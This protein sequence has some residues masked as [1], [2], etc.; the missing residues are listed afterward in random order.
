[1]K[2]IRYII[3]LFAILVLFSACET[4]FDTID[5][6]QDITVVYGLLDQKEQDQYIKINKAFL[7]EGNA[8][9]Y[10]QEADS[11]NYGYL[12]DVS[13]DE[14]SE[15]GDFVR[16]IVLDT[17]T[18]YGK[19]PGVFYADKQVVYHVKLENWDEIK[20]I[21]NYPDTVRIDTMWLNDKSTFKLS[22]KNPRSGKEITSET[23]LVH[24][25]RYSNQAQTINFSTDPDKTTTF[26]WYKAENGGLNEF[27]LMFN[28]KE[29][30][31]NSSDTIEKSIELASSLVSP[32]SYGDENSYIYK[33]ANFYSS[34]LSSIPYND[35]AEE[36]NVV[37]RYTGTVVSRVSVA[38]EELTLYMQVYEPSTSIVQEKPEYTNIENGIGIFSARYWRPQSKNLH[39]DVLANLKS[40]DNNILKFD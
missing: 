35:P 23:K 27:Q 2:K 12:L 31:A 18:V 28:Y 7:G 19:E 30:Y 34:S 22:I 26:S 38:E 6:Y 10:A 32:T 40:I 21:L 25:F 37:A 33:S 29:V 20:Y 13:I 8:L 5:T 39:P 3:S 9:I 36:A 17:T 4:D 16:T 14:I 24:D 1:M 15:D 11:S